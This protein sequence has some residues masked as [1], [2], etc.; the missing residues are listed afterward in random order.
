MENRYPDSGIN[1]SFPEIKEERTILFLLEALCGLFE[2][3]FD[4]GWF[5][6]ILDRMSFSPSVM[7]DIRVMIH[8]TSI[9]NGDLPKLEAGTEGLKEFLEF[10]H[11]SI[12]PVLRDQLGISGFST[13]AAGPADATTDVLKGFFLYTFPHNL[14]RLSELYMQLEPLVDGLRR[15]PVSVPGV[16]SAR[17]VGS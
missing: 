14:R 9:D 3:H 5:L 17:A 6:N 8:L 2:A 4:S 11:R 12:L 10:A 16:H 13:R 1:V 7:R 15:P